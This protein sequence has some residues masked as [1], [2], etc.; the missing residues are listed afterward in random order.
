MNPLLAEFVGAVLRWLLTA[1]AAAMVTK[2]IITNEQ[3]V[4]FVD[5][6]AGWMVPQVALAA[7]LGWSL[8]HKY[9]GHEQRARLEQGASSLGA[10][11]ISVRRT[12]RWQ[13]GYDD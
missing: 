3:A 7:A 2:G 13:H 1:V 10:V 12:G 9:R 6:L 4:R 5:A 8:W 11:D